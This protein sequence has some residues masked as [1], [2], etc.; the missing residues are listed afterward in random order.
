MA[1]ILPET[2]IAMTISIPRVVLDFWVT[3]TLLGRA[4]ATIMEARARIRNPKSS[5][6]ILDKKVLLL[7]NGAKELILMVAVCFFL[8]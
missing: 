1:N 3:S 4:K 5:G 2:S 8:E 6:F 7:A